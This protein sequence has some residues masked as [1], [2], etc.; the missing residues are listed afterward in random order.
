[1]LGVSRNFTFVVYCLVVKLRQDAFC[2]IERDTGNIQE[3]IIEWRR[4]QLVILRESPREDVKPERPRVDDDD[5]RVVRTRIVH[6]QRRRQHLVR[7]QTQHRP[8]GREWGARQG[9]VSRRSTKL[10]A[11]I[12]S[13][14]QFLEAVCNFQAFGGIERRRV[15]SFRMELMANLIA[16]SGTSKTTHLVGY[17]VGIQVATVDGQVLRA[18]TLVEVDT[19]KNV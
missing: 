14:C 1:M 16:L 9:I 12:K 4:R 6:C 5:L 3:R 19:W 15:I 17:A 18:T 13:F 8:V 2:H 10:E 7:Q 11:E